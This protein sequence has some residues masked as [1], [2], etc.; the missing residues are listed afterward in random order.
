MFPEL[1]IRYN[2]YCPI[3]M[4][5][6]YWVK[7]LRMAVELCVSFT[8]SIEISWFFHLRSINLFIL[9]LSCISEI[10]DTLAVMFVI[11]LTFCCI[12][13]HSI[14]R[15]F[16]SMFPYLVWLFFSYAILVRSGINVRLVA[17]SLKM[18][19]SPPLSILW[20]NWEFINDLFMKT[21]Q[22]AHWNHPDIF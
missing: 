10:N 5:R 9:N 4:D 11:H 15:I 20:N 18:E 19:S 12:L 3:S 13:L 2:T 17:L 22:T 16:E 1:L 7:K 8:V 6:I 14:L 21:W